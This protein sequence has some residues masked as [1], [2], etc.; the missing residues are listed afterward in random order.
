MTEDRCNVESGLIYLIRNITNG[1]GYVGL[2]TKDEITR[3]REHVYDSR[4]LKCKYAVHRAIKK[5]GVDSFN[6]TVLETCSTY[7]GLR[8]AEKKWIKELNTHVSNGQGY[9][10]TLGGDGVLGYEFTESHRRNMSIAHT[11]KQFSTEHKKNISQSKMGTKNP[12]FGKSM[13]ETHRSKISASLKGRIFSKESRKKISDA[14]TGKKHT[15]VQ[16]TRKTVVQV[17]ATT[18]DIVARHDS[19][20]AAARSVGNTASPSNILYACKGTRKQAYGYIWRFVD[21]ESNERSSH[22]VLSVG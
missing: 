20:H 3:F 19:V 18:L 4:K 13:L 6:I 8:E 21:N 15:Y 22:E 9:N 2:T 12:M 11:G 16:P 10:M 17:D 1:K 14:L 7:V 5:H